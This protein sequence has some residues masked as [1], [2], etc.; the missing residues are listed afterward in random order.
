MIL[1]LIAID[2]PAGAGKSTTARAVAKR[3]G[4]P[5]LDTGAMYR[6]FTYV[7]VKQG[8]NPNDTGSIKRLI[9]RTDMAFNESKDEFLIWIDGEEISDKLRTTN[10]TKAI[11]KVCEV[12]EVREY[13][14]ALQRRWAVRGFG[15]I[16]GRDIGTVVLP[17]TG[18]KIF[19]TAQPEIRA[20]RRGRDLNIS[21]DHKALAKL[22]KE[23][24]ERDR[25]DMNREESPLRKAKDAI[26][27]DTSNSTF[28]E[29]VDQIVKLAVERFELK[30]YATIKRSG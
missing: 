30:S 5:Y 6:A 21:E 12:R 15:V 25:R 20:A 11:S 3:L 29:Q 22:T 13:L 9:A 1:P 23:I 10:L 8:V 4:I 2:G 17:Q 7:V 16:E 14:V 26:L 19:M 18:L 28:E 27:I 24:A